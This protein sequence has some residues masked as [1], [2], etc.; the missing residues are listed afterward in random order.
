MIADAAGWA[1]G[2][3]DIT[4][5]YTKVQANSISTTAHILILIVFIVF[6]PKVELLSFVNS[7]TFLHLYDTAVRI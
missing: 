6:P 2:D 4:E 1:A 5:V 3:K 7:L